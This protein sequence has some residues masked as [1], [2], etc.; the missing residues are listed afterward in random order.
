MKTKH[1]PRLRGKT[2]VKLPKRFKPR[3]FEEADGRYWLVK[4]LKRRCEALMIDTAADSVQKRMLCQEAVF[5][6]AQLETMR[7]NAAE[8]KSIDFG[9]YTQMLNCLQG[10]LSKL[11]L[12]KQLRRHVS[13]LE[14]YIN[15]K[16]RR[17]TA[18]RR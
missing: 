5:V 12:E 4:E 18:K 16:G 3:V 11:G 14:E 1:K 7:V 15:K 13:A 8:G 10:I 2:R 9:S 6:G 17:R